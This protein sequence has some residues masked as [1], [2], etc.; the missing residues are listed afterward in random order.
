MVTQAACLVSQPLSGPRLPPRNPRAGAAPSLATSLPGPESPAHAL[1]SMSTMGVR[2]PSPPSL[3]FI[4]VSHVDGP[5]AFS[6]Q[7]TAHSGRAHP[8]PTP[9]F[10]QARLTGFFNPAPAPVAILTA[11]AHVPASPCPT[12]SQVLGGGRRASPHPVVLPPSCVLSVMLPPVA[13]LPGGRGSATR[14]PLSPV[15]ETSSG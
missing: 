1:A 11:F 2:D 10:P 12:A 13:I 6:A 14:L 3:G 15:P 5:G 4:C 8:L 9:S 7:T